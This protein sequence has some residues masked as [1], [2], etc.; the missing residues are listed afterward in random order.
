MMNNITLITMLSIGLIG[1]STSPLER[2][3]KLVEKQFEQRED[4]VDE[5]IDNI[6]DWYVQVP[7]PTGSGFYAAGTST[8]RLLK[9]SVMKSTLDA[10]FALAKQ[11]KQLVSGNERSFV[12]ES[13]EGD[14]AQLQSEAQ[15]VVDKLVK[16]V[17]LSGY[18]V[19]DKLIQKEGVTYRSY[20]LLYMPYDAN[21]LV[22]M[23]RKTTRIAAQEAYDE[24]DRRIIE[25]DSRVNDSH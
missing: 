9:T 6:P 23:A 22:K 4:R 24:L 18:K 16:E 2:H 25:S 8:G 1:C 5:V 3:E 19:I 10:E 11:Y 21:N 17:D 20:V 13:G 15:Q 14:N 12:R 7:Q